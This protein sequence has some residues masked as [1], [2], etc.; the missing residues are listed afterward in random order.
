MVLNLEYITITI[1]WSEW[2]RRKKYFY[3]SL[4]RSERSRVRNLAEG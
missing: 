2:W 3:Q 4:W 1:E